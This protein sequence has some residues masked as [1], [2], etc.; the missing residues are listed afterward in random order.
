MTVL[1]PPTK[2]LKRRRRVRA[3]VHGT[4]ERPRISVFRSN[5]GVFAQLIDDDAGRTIAA[6]QWTE[7]DLRSL[8]PMEQATEAGKLLAVA[9]QGRRHRHRRVRSRRLPVPRPCQG[10]GRGRP[11]GR[12]ELLSDALPSIRT[13]WQP[14]IDQSQPLA[15][16]F[17]NA[18]S[19][20]TASPRSSRA[21]GGSR[22]PRW[23]SSATRTASWALA[24]ARPTRSRWRSRRASSARRRTCSGFRATARRSPIRPRASSA[25]A[26]SSSSP[27]PPVPA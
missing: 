11:R 21:A 26:A 9:R 7:A 23:S 6:V 22:S 13:P 1:S 18:S 24:T 2:R 3:K 4:A 25:P 20:S 16:T 14:P 15:S 17:R 10:P 8:K 19:R 12:P 5:R 27:R